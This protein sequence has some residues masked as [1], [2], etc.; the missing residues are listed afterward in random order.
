[1]S[2]GAALSKDYHV[3]LSKVWEISGASVD[4]R[5]ASLRLTKSS[6]LPIAGMMGDC[7]PH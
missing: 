4:V 3:W 1:M 5:V 6:L 2:V 7:L